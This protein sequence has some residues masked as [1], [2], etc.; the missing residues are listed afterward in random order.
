M[1]ISTLH[2][3]SVDLPPVLDHRPTLVMGSEAQGLAEKVAEAAEIPINRQAE[4]KRKRDYQE[5]IEVPVEDVTEEVSGVA[6]AASLELVNVPPEN[7][8]RK[9][10]RE[11]VEKKVAEQDAKD[12]KAALRRELIGNIKAVGWL[13]L[14]ALVTAIG[15][16][17]IFSGNPLGAIPLMLGVQFLCMSH[18]H[19]FGME[20]AEKQLT[21]L[22]QAEG[23]RRQAKLD[24][25]FT[26]FLK[27][28]L[29]PEK[30]YIGTPEQS[31]LDDAE[32]RE[33]LLI[34]MENDAFLYRDFRDSKNN[35]K[36]AIDRE[37]AEESL[38]NRLFNIYHLKIKDSF[39]EKAHAKENIQKE[40]EQDMDESESMAYEM[41]NAGYNPEIMEKFRKQFDCDSFVFL[42]EADV[43]K[44]KNAKVGD[45]DFDFNFIE[46]EDINTVEKPLLI[47]F[48]DND[49]TL[50]YLPYISKHM[51]N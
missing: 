15:V 12:I 45:A 42:P 10:F 46:F 21:D 9:K 30:H 11:I 19:T 5:K 2:F 33:S 34:R 17:L 49:G 40:A 8:N 43:K 1:Q 48:Y 26:S 51:S 22:H 36:L 6:K 13:L 29:D 35:F 38:N 24:T 16:A 18:H 4:T 31:V 23:L 32:K 20:I 7:I 44:I 37:E 41:L 47:G 14:A 27:D 50:R 28:Q 39:I 25:R 3:S